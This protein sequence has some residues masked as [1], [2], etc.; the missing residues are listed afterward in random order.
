MSLIIIWFFGDLYKMSYYH[1]T[2]SPLPLVLCTMFQC[3][4]DVAIMLQFFLYSAKN[5]EMEAKN[6]SVADGKQ[7]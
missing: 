6:K 3:A 5:K 2:G 7:D 4:T 1:S